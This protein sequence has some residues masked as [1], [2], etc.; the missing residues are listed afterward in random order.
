MYAPII[1]LQVIS[2]GLRES[3]SR[4]SSLPSLVLD[5]SCFLAVRFVIMPVPTGDFR[6]GAQRTRV[7]LQKARSIVRCASSS[8][9]PPQ[10]RIVQEGECVGVDRSRKCSVPFC[11]VEWCAVGRMF[12]GINLRASSVRWCGLA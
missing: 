1:V 3:L 9:Y 8:L 2:Q 12:L 7:R 6:E 5:G 4:C 10:E 11:S